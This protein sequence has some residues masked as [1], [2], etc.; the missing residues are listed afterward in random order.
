MKKQPKYDIFISYRRD[1]GESTAKILRDKLSELGYQVFFDVES[2]RSGDFN[3]RLYSV[4][5]ECQDFL[6]ILS[7]G[8]LDRCRNEDDWVRLEIEHALE[9][10][11]NVIPVML[12]GFSFPQ[13]LPESIDALRYKN[14]VESNY[15]FF[16]AFIEKLRL[17]LKSKPAIGRRIGRR[18][19]GK[20][21][22]LAFALMAVLGAGAAVG[23]DRLTE[24][25]AYPSNKKEENLTGSLIYYVQSNLLRMEQAAEYM[26]GAYN[27]CSQYLAHPDT[28]SR[29]ELLSQL[30]GNR[31]LL[32]GIDAE[33][34]SMTEELR[35]GLEESPF[36]LADSQAL[37]DYL[38]EFRQSCISNIYFMEYI[39]DPD[40]YLEQQVRESV[41]GCYEEIL[42]EELQ[43]IAC[44]INELL[45]PIEKEESL[46]AFKYDFLPQLYYIPLEAST[47]SDSREALAS[48]E[49]SSWN[50]IERS[51][52]QV[53]VQI[54][55]ENMKLMETKAQMVQE[56]MESGLSQQEAEER[57]NE[58]SGQSSQLTQEKDAL[59]EAQAQ[60]EE[61]LNEAREK[62]A[63]QES[64]DMEMLW[65]KMLRFL[66]LGLY[67]EALNCLDFYR[68]KARGQDAYAE[69]YVP[70]ARR[71]IES[72]G[73]TGIDYGLMV[74]G[75]EPGQESHEQYEIGDVIIALNGLPVHNYEEYSRAKESLP[76][77]TDYQVIV[78]RQEPGDGN[79][80]TET[81]LSI[82]G[83]GPRVQIREM[84]EK[85][86]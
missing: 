78:L 48:G 70:A 27:A 29:E 59:Q 73:Q 76:S 36:S 37:H 68:E 5:E 17:F 7:P 14:G 75:Y 1:G 79:N 56:L 69:L 64:D 71:F 44:G 45:L 74:V 58:L 72:V 10:G 32:Y 80:L 51:M 6:L 22:L 9:T 2:L 20:N 55:E 15:Q 11:K 65:G 52:D 84:T 30:E 28:A 34:V 85:T 3:T 82:P 81:E 53:R 83:D 77:G 4:I 31:R 33:A 16:D 18:P 39:T 46:E 19:L 43:V 13:V 38:E 24:D 67:D 21:L 49:E 23:L 41:L 50:A 54:G 12:R 47:W 26:D 8:A 66:N 42:E 63:P 57:M 61:K 60:L 35:T 25:R 62:F 86:Y 40:T